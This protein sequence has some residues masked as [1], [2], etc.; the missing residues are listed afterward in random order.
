MLGLVC[1]IRLKMVGYE[2]QK[3]FSLDRLSQSNT[4]ITNLADSSLF[5]SY[6]GCITLSTTVIY[7]D[8]FAMLDNH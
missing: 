4:T 7:Y 2:T 3:F 1:C 6:C 8:S 5:W